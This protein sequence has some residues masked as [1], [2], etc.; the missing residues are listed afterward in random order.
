MEQTTKTWA[1]A[2]HSHSRLLFLNVIK[3]WECFHKNNIEKI[4]KITA[5][6]PRF[7]IHIV[8]YALQDDPK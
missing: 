3:V 5:H 8:P 6:A 1:C 2:T 4:N 7:L